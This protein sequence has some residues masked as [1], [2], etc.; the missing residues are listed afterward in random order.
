MNNAVWFYADASRQ[1]QGPVDGD[2]LAELLRAGRIDAR[3]LL[4]RDGLA[5]WQPLSSLGDELPWVRSA[6]VVA[7]TPPPIPMSAPSSAA[8]VVRKGM[9]MGAGCAIAVVA[10]LVAVPVIGILAAI[11]IP[12]YQ[13][14]TKRALLM[15][16]IIS[17]TP[18]KLRIAEA[19]QRDGGCPTELGIASKDVPAG[20][21]EV[22][23][24]RFEDGTCGAQFTF[25]TVARLP[26]AQGKK[27]WFWLDESGSDWK[28]SSDLANRILPA[29]CR[30]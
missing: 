21:S 1:Q 10:G 6:L 16:H 9:G 20:F 13:D 11:A 28:C 19:F 25:D 24:G 14:Y 3:T 12:A 30:S 15:Q 5:S 4:W 27:L 29:N 7:T 2:T 26:E 22:W 23:V 8:P 17:A 18:I